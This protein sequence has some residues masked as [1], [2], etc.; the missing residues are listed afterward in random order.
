MKL[1]EAKHL[2]KDT[3]KRI[4][5]GIE[6]WDRFLKS[7][8]HVYRYSFADQVMIYAQKPEATALMFQMNIQRSW[9][10]TFILWM[11]VWRQRLRIWTADM[12]RSELR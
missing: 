10:M 8:A 7:A 2:E 4:R 5:S 6:E 12:R 11:K 1:Y 3:L 9:Q